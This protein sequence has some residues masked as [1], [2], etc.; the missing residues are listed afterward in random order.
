MKRLSKLREYRTDLDPSSYMVNEHRQNL[1]SIE[2]SF[3]ALNTK[4]YVVSELCT[5]FSTTS[6]SYDNITNLSAKIV[7]NGGPVVVGVM[8]VYGSTDA[9]I[10]SASNCTLKISRVSIENVATDIS[11]RPLVGSA[12]NQSCSFQFFDVVAAGTYTYKV[13]LKS[14]NGVVNNLKLFAYEIK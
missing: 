3:T 9:G 5:T 11:I 14:S 8:E 1:R 13:S 12:S 10:I 6:G 4:N 2:D 7:T